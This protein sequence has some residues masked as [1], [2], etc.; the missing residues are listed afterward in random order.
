MFWKQTPKWS[1]R[2]ASQRA[3][4]A[5]A[6]SKHDTEHKRRRRDLMNS[7]LG[8]EC[9]GENGNCTPYPLWHSTWNFRGNPAPK[10]FRFGWFRTSPPR[11]SSECLRSPLS[12]ATTEDHVNG[13]L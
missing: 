1:A 4:G 11:T 12:Q 10:C 3:D 2:T 7:K 8:S 5:R 6:Q 9:L 13:P